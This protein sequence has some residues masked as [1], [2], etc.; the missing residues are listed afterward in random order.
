MS[1]M[2]AKLVA[3]YCTSTLLLKG[4]LRSVKK[5]WNV[6][7]SLAGCFGFTLPRKQ[8]ELEHRAHGSKTILQTIHGFVT[9]LRTWHEEDFHVSILVLCN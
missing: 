3:G 6:G 8:F 7:L 9:A 2:L 1:V 4:L 5:L